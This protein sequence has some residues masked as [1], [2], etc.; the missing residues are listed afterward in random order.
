MNIWKLIFWVVVLL[1]FGLPSMG[2]QRDE[3]SE[4]NFPLHLRQ[5]PPPQPEEIGEGDCF[6][7]A[8]G[9]APIHSGPSWYF[10]SIGFTTNTELR[11]LAGDAVSA[12]ADYWYE[13]PF[14]SKPG[15][16]PE[17]NV[18]LYGDCDQYNENRFVSEFPYRPLAE[19]SYVG[20]LLACQVKLITQTLNGLTL[21][22][23]PVF[24]DLL[25]DTPE[26]LISTTPGSVYRALGY[27]N[28]WYRTEEIGWIHESFVAEHVD[29][30]LVSPLLP[31]SGRSW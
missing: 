22:Q 21:D 4:A 10:S 3:V 9:R 31:I 29:G 24:P 30:C 1:A 19:Y 15:W 26:R 23:I 2:I 16:V 7:T 28:G 20:P 25:D 6:L 8:V 5:A 18:S 12:G 14:D 13:V 17:V 11:V 27:A